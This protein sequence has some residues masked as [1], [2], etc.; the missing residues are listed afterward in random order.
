MTDHAITAA[1]DNFHFDR[2]SDKWWETETC[3]FSFYQPER[4]LGG[5]LYVMVRPNIGTV[6][7]GAWVW[8]ASAHLPWEVLYSAN[9][10]CLRLGD[11]RDLR[12]AT[13]ATGV[14][15]KM[16][17][18]LR[19]YQLAYED[20]ERLKLDL[21]FDAVMAPMPLHSKTSAFGGLGHFDQFGRVRGQVVVNGETLV[22]DSLS[23]RDRSWG[24]RPEHR[25]KRSTYVTGMADENTGFLLMS[26][27]QRPG[28]PMTHGF[29]LRDGQ[30][31]HL[32]SGS[33]NGDYDTTEGWMRSLKVE[34]TDALGRS[35]VANGVA[36]SRI[37]LNRHS[38]IDMNSLV[39]WELDGQTAWGED[40]DIWTMHQWAD[41]RRGLKAA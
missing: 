18:P 13:F 25:P 3:W 41:M 22:I 34:G 10:S 2:M 6:A 31:A 12:D 16:L 14:K 37:V 15:V 39:R 40:Q 29:L 33:R 11:A 35:F 32:V 27:P 30:A 26:D 20:G 38:F 5:W 21:Q 7:G 4:K 28:E 9:Y 17:E 19:R 1:D 36:Q 23:M 8:D 24:P